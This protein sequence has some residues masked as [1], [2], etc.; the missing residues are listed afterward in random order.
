M[1]FDPLL[2]PG[3]RRPAQTFGSWIAVATLVFALMP[4]AAAQAKD[5]PTITAKPRELIDTTAQQ[6]VAILGRWT[7][8][9]KTD[10]RDSGHRL[11]HL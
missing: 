8:R 7:S 11:R 6:I 5:D 1:I 10:L 9:L 3:A 4:G 2:E